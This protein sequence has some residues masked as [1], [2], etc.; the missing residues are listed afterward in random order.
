MW[1]EVGVW[2]RADAKGEKKALLLRRTN[3]R[4]RCGRV[5]A[6]TGGREAAAPA[7]QSLRVSPANL[8]RLVKPNVKS[9]V[10]AEL[11][12]SR[13]LRF[14]RPLPCHRPP[15]IASLRL[16]SHPTRF[17]LFPS[18]A[19][20]LLKGARRRHRAAILSVLTSPHLHSCKSGRTV[21][22]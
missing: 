12:R 18:L 6:E 4:D 17:A 8:K 20:R 14:S 5:P 9:L 3:Q 21:F 7:L 15:I 11:G 22:G 1:L 19:F 16:F 10:R 2:A 13:M